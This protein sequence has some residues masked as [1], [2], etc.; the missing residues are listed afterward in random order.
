MSV[1]RVRENRTHGSMRRREATQGPV[2]NAAR[3]RL[4][5]RRPYWLSHKSRALEKSPTRIA[6]V[7]DDTA[8]V[9][10]INVGGVQAVVEIN[11]ERPSS[12]TYAT[13]KPAGRSESAGLPLAVPASKRQRGDPMVPAIVATCSLVP[14][15]S[16]P[17]SSYAG[18]GAP[19]RTLARSRSGRSAS[20]RPA[21][22]GTGVGTGPATP[23]HNGAGVAL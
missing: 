14:A 7:P 22:R 15:G 13:A 19:S 20:S 1:S 16:T 2:G 21:G 11:N 17:M 6:G 9:W 12:R 5:S 8:P 3:S 4:A 18:L 10:R 23:R